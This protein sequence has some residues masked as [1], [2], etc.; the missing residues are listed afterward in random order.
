MVADKYDEQ[1]QKGDVSFFLEKDYT[2]DL[3]RL[4]NNTDVLRIIDNSLRNPIRNMTD[5]N[6]SHCMKY[7]QLLG[8]LSDVYMTTV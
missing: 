2:Q 7:I 6:K 3:S 8:K 4:K 1:I 5:I